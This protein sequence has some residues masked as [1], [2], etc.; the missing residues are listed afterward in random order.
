MISESKS[1]RNE[2]FSDSDRIYDGMAV[3]RVRTIKLTWNESVDT[4]LE[5]V[6]IQ[7]YLQ[8]A[9]IQIIM[10]TY[11][12]NQIKDMTLDQIG[13]SLNRTK[14]KLCPNI[15]M[16]AIIFLTMMRTKPN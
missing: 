13:E 5:A 1:T 12:D 11:D 3:T 6:T 8:P 14:D 10:A 9:S 4:F 7:E 2:V 16:I 15:E